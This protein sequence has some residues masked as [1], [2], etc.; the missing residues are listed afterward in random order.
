MTEFEQVEVPEST[1]ELLNELLAQNR[2]VVEQNCR[3]MQMLGT[4]MIL[5]DVDKIKRDAEELNDG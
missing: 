4:P 1:R 2:M 5:G 3:M